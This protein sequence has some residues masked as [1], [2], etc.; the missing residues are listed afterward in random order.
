MRNTFVKS[1]TAQNDGSASAPLKLANK[2]FETKQEKTP[3]RQAESIGA[4]VVI[5][6]EE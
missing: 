3:P 1:W 4:V 5:Q 6:E 2:P